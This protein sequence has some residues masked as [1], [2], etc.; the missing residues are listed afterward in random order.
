MSGYLWKPLDEE[1]IRNPYAMYAALRRNDPVHQAQTG[2]FIITRYED[3][4]N[5]LKDP[6]F[7]SGNRLMWLKK[8]IQYFNSKQEDFRAIYR[9]MNSF[10]LMLNDEKH[11]R[12]RNFIAR[13]W[14]D[15]DV[16]PLIEKNIHTV[17][18]RMPDKEVDV[19][20]HFAQPL[21]VLTIAGIL[22]APVTDYQHLIQLGVAMTKTLDLYVSMKDLVVM[23][24]AAKLF[25][26]YFREQVKLKNDKA[27]DGL[28]SKL[29]QKNRQENAGLTE[30]ELISIG[31]FLFTA[32]EE[33]SAG[34]I[35]NTLLHLAGNPA[36][37]ALLR[38]NPEQMDSAIDEVLRYD[39]VV[40]LLGRT[41]SRDIVIRDKRIKSGS[42]ITLVIGSAN[43]DE[44]AFEQAD[45]FIIS[46]KPNRHLS[47]GSGV[48]YCL[49][50]WLGR[51]QS[52][53]AVSAF[54]KQYPN[55]TL[56][57]QQLSWY[58]NIAVRRLDALRISV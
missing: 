1:N 12:I 22:G 57:P 49:G 48:H 31:I 35:S 26:D 46:R 41:A 52:Q 2:E 40:Q 17:L 50:D 23:N 13:A 51:R 8:G 18:R 16:D 43:R 25:I 32:G 29:I 9:A 4:K 56:P 7:K 21:P 6:S 53:L 45:E 42:A 55:I 24:D 47:F 27:D 15:R 37:L 36:Q 19:V 38:Q 34:L 3:I 20:A 33:T 11:L 58:K 14:N 5:I 10:I 54:L 30:E 44:E 28:F 39:S